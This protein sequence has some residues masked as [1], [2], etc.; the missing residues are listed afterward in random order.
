MKAEASADVVPALTTA[1]HST[2]AVYTFLSYVANLQTNPGE[3]ITS[4]VE[5]EIIMIKNSL[6]TH[7]N[8]PSG[9][10][11]INRIRANNCEGHV[12]QIVF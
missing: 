10:E 1:T 2:S 3:M 5:I 9:G 12:I 8:H 7:K 11:I 6:S 4:L